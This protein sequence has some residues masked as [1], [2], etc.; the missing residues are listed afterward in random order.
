M[1]APYRLPTN[2][3]I[4]TARAKGA[5]DDNSTPKP[6]DM[7]EPANPAAELS[8]TKTDAVAAVALGDPHH[9]RIMTGE[10]KIPPPRPIIPLTNPIQP[11][12]PTRSP[13][14]PGAS[15]TSSSS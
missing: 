10:R 5:I 6:S 3:P 14:K 13:L 7:V 9:L 12:S 4:R 8:Q 11:P 2:P 1:P 15:N